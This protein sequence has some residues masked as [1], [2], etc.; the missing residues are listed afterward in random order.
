MAAARDYDLTTGSIASHFRKLAIPAALGMLFTTLY[1]VVD[2][3]FAGQIGTESQAGLAIGFQAFFVLVAVAFGLSSAM[4]AL[5]GNARGAKDNRAARRLAVQGLAFATVATIVLMI[6]AIWF[7]PRAIILISEP[8]EYRDAAT[9]YFYWLVAALPGF[10]LA[11]SANGI[12]QAHG[13]SVTL[14]RGQ[15]VAFFANIAL[16]PLFIYGI[17]GV[18]GGMG[19][20]GIALATILSQTGVMVWILWTVSR[21]EIMQGVEPRHVRLEWATVKEI[22]AQMLPT[23]TAMMVMFVSGFVVQYALKGFGE[24]AIAAYGIALRIEQILLLPVLGMTG[25][26]LPIAAQN[27]GAKNHARVREAVWFC[28]K[29]G[30]VMTAL[31]APILWFGGGLAMS[32]FTDD[33]DVIPIGQ[34]Y[35]RVDGFLFPLYMMLFAINSLLQALKKPV[36]T[37]WISLYRQGFGVAFFVWL[38]IGVFGM[39][40]WGVWLGIGAAVSTGW[41]IAL[42]ITI[43]I[44]KEKIGGLRG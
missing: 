23:T 44:A 16:N 30:F 29:L 39:D 19:F 26:L 31:A 3:Y 28:W 11:F 12:L 14:Q 37:L 32:I 17:P 15:M 43:R 36:Y 6:F 18:I 1:N 27:Y 24:E 5:V 38:L 40:V 8:G 33:T 34:S 13:D 2:V 4:S 21:L 9:G 20:N 7:G 22:L 35:L 25:A 41:A 42:W 10:I